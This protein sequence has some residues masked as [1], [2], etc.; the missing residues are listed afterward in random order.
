MWFH[1]RKVNLDF[2]DIAER[3]YVVEERVCAARRELWT[4]IVDPTT[5]SHWWPGV[6]SA[7]YRGAAPSYGVG[8]L[9]EAR[10]GRQ[11]YE[12]IVVAWDEGRRWAYCIERATLPIA[13]AQLECTEL[14][15][16]DGGTRVRWIL[17]QNP[18]LLMRLSAPLFPRIM[19]AMFRQ[20]MSNLERYVGGRR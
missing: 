16:S 6:V 19:R 11:R 9:R 17:A 12:E 4:A 18:R 1:L 10:V 7:S 13:T 8:T 20:A 5:W 3:K 2:L 15:D 14:E